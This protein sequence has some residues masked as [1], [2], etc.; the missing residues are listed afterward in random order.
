ME[1]MD[2]ASLRKMISMSNKE[3]SFQKRLKRGAELLTKME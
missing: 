3:P 1:A 2:K